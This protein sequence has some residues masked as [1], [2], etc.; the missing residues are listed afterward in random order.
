MAV[1]AETFEAMEAGAPIALPCDALGPGFDRILE[2]FKGS[3]IA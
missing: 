1:P 3:A 2:G